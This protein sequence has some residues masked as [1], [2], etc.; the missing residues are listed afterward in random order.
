VLAMMDQNLSWTTS[1]GEAYMGASQ[2]V[3][4]AV[5]QMRARAE[6]A[7]NLKSTP[8]ENVTD[9][10][11]TIMIE[12]AS[13]EVVYLPDYD[14]WLVYGAPEVFYPGWVPVPGV[15]IDEPG[16][17]FGFGI[18]IGAF[19][20]FGWGW[21]HWRADW[22]RHDVFFDHHPYVS[23]GPAFW[24]HHVPTAFSHPGA[25]RSGVGF[26]GGFHA[27]AFPGARPAG[28]AY[29]GHSF[30]PGGFDRGAGGARFALH[31]GGFGGFHGSVGGAR[32]GAHIGG[33]HGGIGGFHGGHVGGGHR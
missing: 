27:G 10:A 13:P 14:P 7:G 2:S 6:Q 12:P 3:M 21:D 25:F 32:A 23:H 29:G 8:Q 18:G 9:E 33:F 16:I 24:G 28:F 30:I 15:F 19:G 1:L 5:Q 4:N 17:V 11:Q 20:G 26:T 31:G 22:H